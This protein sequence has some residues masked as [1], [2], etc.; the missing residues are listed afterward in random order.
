MLCLGLS[1]KNKQNMVS[2]VIL[3]YG[4]NKKRE[5]IIKPKRA[6]EVAKLE[7]IQK[8]QATSNQTANAIELRE[9][10]ENF[11]NL[12]LENWGPL[13]LKNKQNNNN[14]QSSANLNIGGGN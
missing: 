14:K 13:S 11:L 9:K 2:E 10:K 1:V 5:G 3:L 6:N 7:R 4:L 12:L 8:Q